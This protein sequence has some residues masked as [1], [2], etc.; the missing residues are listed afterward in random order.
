MFTVE[1]DQ[2]TEVTIRH[3]PG[4]TEIRKLV[5]WYPDGTDSAVCEPIDPRPLVKRANEILFIETQYRGLAKE[6]YGEFE[7]LRDGGYV[8]PAGMGRTLEDE[9]DHLHKTWPP[10]ENWITQAERFAEERARR[11]FRDPRFLRDVAE[12]RA[13]HTMKEACAQFSSDEKTIREW[14][15]AAADYGLDWK[16]MKGKNE[17]GE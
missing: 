10:P 6:L 12:F 11:R 17:A 2:W 8:S 1:L 9:V 16:A 13:G 3:L 7:A 4:R 5:V 15:R 14:L